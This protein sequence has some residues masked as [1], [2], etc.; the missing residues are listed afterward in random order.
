ME[1]G[2]TIERSTNPTIS[3]GVPVNNGTAAITKYTVDY[4]PA[5]DFDPVTE[6]LTPVKQL[7]WTSATLVSSSTQDGT[8]YDGD[9]PANANGT[10]PSDLILQNI[11]SDFTYYFRVRA[12]TLGKGYGTPSIIKSLGTLTEPVI[13]APVTEEEDWDFGITT[14]NGGC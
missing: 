13:S 6:V 10:P 2:F 1:D 11:L 5:Y 12:F 14:F 4:A 3:W 9:V 7:I 8:R